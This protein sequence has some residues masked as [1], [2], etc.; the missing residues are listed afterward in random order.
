MRK[1][2]E[3]GKEYDLHFLE[4]DKFGA[5]VRT[6]KKKAYGEPRT[7]ARRV[8][9]TLEELADRTGVVLVKGE[10]VSDD[11]ASGAYQTKL[12]AL[13]SCKTGASGGVGMYAVMPKA[14]ENSDIYWTL[15]EVE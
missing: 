2:T 5:A 6:E 8:R 12:A 1:I 9:V 7:L 10:N 4:L 14:D 15:E 11:A 13:K 3:L